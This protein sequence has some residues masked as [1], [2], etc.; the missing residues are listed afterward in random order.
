MPNPS[1]KYASD[2]ALVSLGVAI[3]GIRLVRGFSQEDLAL[4]SQIERSYMSSIERGMQNVGVMT[5][6]RICA[7]LGVSVAELMSAAKL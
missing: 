4:Q 5:L 7:T 2:P 1:P 6:V 3:R